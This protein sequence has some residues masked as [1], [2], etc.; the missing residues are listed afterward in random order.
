MF[1]AYFGYLYIDRCVW[2]FDFHEEKNWIFRG[3]MIEENAADK[4]RKMKDNFNG[5]FEKGT[6]QFCQD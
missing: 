4:R 6:V 3:Y 2:V 5:I 1:T